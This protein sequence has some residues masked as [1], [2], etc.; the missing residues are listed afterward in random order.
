MNTV[1]GRPSHPSSNSDPNWLIE[2]RSKGIELF[3]KLGTPTVRDENWRFSRVSKM[4]T[5]GYSQL[6]EANTNRFDALNE[7]SNLISQCAGRTIFIDDTVSIFEGVSNE[8]TE[9]GVIFLP[10]LEAIREHPD[11]ME[12]YFLKE[13]TELGSQKFFGL[14]ASAVKAG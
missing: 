5:E 14:H 11:L 12:K 7:R 8:L 1:L 9:K 10:I 3:E 13:S 4:S 2:R 6:E